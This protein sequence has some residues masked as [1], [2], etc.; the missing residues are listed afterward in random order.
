MYLNTKS[1]TIL[2]I[3][4]HHSFI[5]KV[6]H[7]SSMLIK[8]NQDEIDTLS[9]K[10]QKIYPWYIQTKLWPWWQPILYS[11]V[12]RDQNWNYIK[13]FTTY[14]T[15]FGKKEL[16]LLQS[17][18]HFSQKLSTDIS[19]PKI[20]S[21]SDS[22]IFHFVL[23][24]LQAEWFKQVDFQKI[25]TNDAF[26]LYK[27]Y[28]D[29]CDTY[30][31]DWNLKQTIKYRE[32]DVRDS[33]QRQFK[34]R[35]EM[36]KSNIKL[37]LPDI[38]IEKVKETYKCLHTDCKNFTAEYTI[39]SFF[40]WHVFYNTA[41]DQIKIIDL[42]ENY[43]VVWHTLLQIAYSKVLLPVHTYSSYK[44]R[45]IEVTERFE[46][47]RKEINNSSLTSLLL[48]KKIV[49]IL[50]A[51]FGYNMTTILKNRTTVE[52]FGIDPDENAKKWIKWYYTLLQKLYY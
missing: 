35:L 20:I 31:K 19:W 16:R 51:D 41:T 49:W 23:S 34:K 8:N 6:I 46:L 22:P 29:F 12:W 27:R 40:G 2:D 45:E 47:I 30:I 24:D 17:V 14:W 33:Q 44:V 42:E 13:A 28:R 15:A 7:T 9:S 39:N 52:S 21:V 5:S 25:S 3:L 43:R 4:Y 10:I 37:V 1:I 32:H 48:Y 26:K 18:N 36:W 38:D 50:F 11:T